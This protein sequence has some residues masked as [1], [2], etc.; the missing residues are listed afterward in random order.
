MK[1]EW[2]YDPND[3]TCQDSG[4]VSNEWHKIKRNNDLYPPHIKWRKQKNLKKQKN[5]KDMLLKEQKYKAIQSL[6]LQKKNS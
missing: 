2:H 5:F 6:Y 4:A 1:H 3:A